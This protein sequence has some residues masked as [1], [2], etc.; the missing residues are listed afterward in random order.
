MYKSKCKWK[1][2]CKAHK[3]V[4]NRGRINRE[5]EGKGSPLRC[6]CL[7]N[8][9]DRGAWRATVH[10]VAES[11]T[12]LS[13][14]QKTEKRCVSVR[15][16]LRICQGPR[17]AASSLTLQE[18]SAVLTKPQGR[19]RQT[20]AVTLHLPRACAC[21][22]CSVTVHLKPSQQSRTPGTKRTRGLGS[23][24]WASAQCG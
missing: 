18:H 9:M 19:P 16:A 21:D 13:T 7:E 4:I 14:A 11:W 20:S 23:R 5:G 8:T 12:R 17:T 6:S 10:G 3:Q 2:C 24:R 15:E 22:S 1:K